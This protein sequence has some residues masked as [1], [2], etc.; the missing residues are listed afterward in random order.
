MN[1]KAIIKEINLLKEPTE[2]FYYKKFTKTYKKLKL[3]EKNNIELR[4]IIEEYK[5][6]EFY[7]ESGENY[8]LDDTVIL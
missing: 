2:L 3:V 1:K 4:K 7:K 8:I 6:K 5:W